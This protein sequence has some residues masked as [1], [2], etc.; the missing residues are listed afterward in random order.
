MCL[1]QILFVWHACPVQWHAVDV[2]PRADLGWKP[3]VALTSCGTLDKLPDFSE[4]P[5]PH[6]SNSNI[7]T[8]RNVADCRERDVVL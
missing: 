6:M 8:S 7:I 4:S 1:A 2:P 3:G 5:F